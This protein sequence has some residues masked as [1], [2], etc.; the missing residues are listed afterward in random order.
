MN[1]PITIDN[2]TAMPITE[3]VANPFGWLQRQAPT[4]YEDRAGLIAALKDRSERAH[5][6]VI[7][8][9]QVELLHNPN[10]Q[11]K[12]DANQLL[13]AIN[14]NAVGMTHWSFGQLAQLAKAPAAYL[15]SLPAPYVKDCLEYGLRHVR[16]VED[17]KP[18]FD[19]HELRAVTG[20]GY[21]RVDDYLVAEAVASILDDNR[22]VPADE[23]MGFS[24]TDRSLQMFMIDKENPVV[25][26]KTRNGDDDVM[27]RGLR[28]FN[29]EL[30]YSSL[31]IE[32]FLFRS[33]CLNGCIFGMQEAHTITVRHSKNAPYRWAREV[34]PALEAYASED[35]SKLVDQVTNLKQSLVAHDDDKAV[36]FLNNR[37]MSRSMAR[38]AIE[39]VEVEEGSHARTAWDLVQGV[40]AVA[41]D[42]HVAEDRADLERMAG[43]IWSKFAA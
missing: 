41:R 6:Q 31:G 20:P 17:I 40:T 32:G 7:E 37:G 24:V 2:A 5:S 22:W 16:E 8:N 39:R 43:N 3:Q 26:G 15:R 23:H 18:Y 19:G 11:T 30:G 35:G 12:D 4:R 13:F 9:A 34:Q 36:A 33:Y 25:V 14:G 1:A 28:I 38:Q 42:I 27:Y 29:S 21:G 10:I